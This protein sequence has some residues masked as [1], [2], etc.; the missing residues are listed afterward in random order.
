MRN[1]WREK[2]DEKKQPCS[3]GD[4]LEGRG[5][6]DVTQGPASYKAGT[7]PRLSVQKGHSGERILGRRDHLEPST[8]SKGLR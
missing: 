5:R 4:G 1:C 3:G 6:E 7:A 8:Q 2:V